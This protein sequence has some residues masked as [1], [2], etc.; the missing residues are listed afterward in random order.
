[1][2]LSNIRGERVFDVIADL[3]EPIAN[4]AQDEKAAQF[5]HGVVPKDGQTPEEAV[6]EKL[7]ESVPALI[8]G[9]R[10]DLT[11]ILAALNGQEPEEY[12]E[13]MTLQSLVGDVYDLLTDRDFLA[14]LS[15]LA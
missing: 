4:I 5:F 8:R 10:G 14:F 7:R 9:H 2:R 13:A 15:S 11:R 1:M 12:A 3:I 6:V